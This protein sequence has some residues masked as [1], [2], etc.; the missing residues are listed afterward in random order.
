MSNKEYL[1]KYGPK[2]INV[3]EPIQHILDQL[4]YEDQWDL[5][6]FFIKLHTEKREG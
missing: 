5:L 4:S 1:E 2:P 3:F 6:D